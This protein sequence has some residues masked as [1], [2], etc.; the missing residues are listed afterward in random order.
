MVLAVKASRNRSIYKWEN[1]KLMKIEN[2]AKP[3]SE[4]RTAYEMFLRSIA[5]QG[6]RER[7]RENDKTCVNQTPFKQFR[8]FQNCSEKILVGEVGDYCHR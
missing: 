1:S 5:A 3:D 4:P 8:H 6:E 7:K 2:F